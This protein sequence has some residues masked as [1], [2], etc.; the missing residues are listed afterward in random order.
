M[1]LSWSLAC[2]NISNPPSAK[3]GIICFD[4]VYLHV[5]ALAATMFMSD[6]PLLGNAQVRAANCAA[7]KITEEVNMLILIRRRVM[8]ML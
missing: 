3:E 5:T 7:Q 2:I 4:M 8:L 6:L 1:S